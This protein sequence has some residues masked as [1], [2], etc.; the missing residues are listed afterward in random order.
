MYYAHLSIRILPVSTL[1]K[2]EALNYYIC[3]YI[4]HCQSENIRKLILSRAKF[5]VN[6]LLG[7]WYLFSF[8]IL[9]THMT[10]LNVGNP[11]IELNSD[12]D[13]KGSLHS[14]FYFYSE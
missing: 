1:G 8:S 12:L 2:K 10:F 5:G 11:Q 6:D 14:F 7:S 4:L 9:C 3:V 13:L